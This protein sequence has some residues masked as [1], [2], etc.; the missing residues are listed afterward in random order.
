MR[1]LSREDVDA[2]A[3]RVVELME[4][5]DV[6]PKKPLR[7]VNADELAEVLGVERKWIYQHADELGVRRLGNSQ[8]ARLRFDV[9]HA[10]RVLAARS[11]SQPDE[12]RPRGRP[13]RGLQGRRL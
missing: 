5:R 12:S 2:V 13:R 10:A 3:E 8:R 9:E 7:L 11:A 4:E 1:T 6:A